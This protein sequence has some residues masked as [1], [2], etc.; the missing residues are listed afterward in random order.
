MVV[1]ADHPA[2]V[3]VLKQHDYVAGIVPDPD[4]IGM[5]PYRFDIQTAVQ[6]ARIEVG[7]TPAEE[8]T[9]A[10]KGTLRGSFNTVSH[11]KII[12]AL[13]APLKEDVR[14]RYNLSRLAQVGCALDA[15]LQAP[16]EQEQPVQ[17]DWKQSAAASDEA[18]APGR[19]ALTLTVRQ[20]PEELG[21]DPDATP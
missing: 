17:V 6:G 5:G 1:T 19:E 16:L 20:L 2:L 4:V 21:E 10:L 3:E 18:A 11:P 15:I 9:V 12:R 13:R 7:I 8:P 14:E